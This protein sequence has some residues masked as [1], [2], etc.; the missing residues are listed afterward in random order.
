MQQRRAFWQRRDTKNVQEQDRQKEGKG[1]D[2]SGAGKSWASPGWLTQL[3]QLWGGNSVRFPPRDEQPVFLM[4][5]H[6]IV[7]RRYLWLMPSPKT[8]RTFW[9]APCSRHCTSGCWR[10]GLSTFFPLALCPVSLWYRILRLQNTCF[11]QQTTCSATSTTRAW[12]QRSRNSCLEKALPSLAG[13]TGVC[14]GRPCPLRFTGACARHLTAQ[15]THHRCGCPPSHC[16]TYSTPR[17]GSRDILPRGLLQ[18]CTSW[19]LSCPHTRPIKIPS[20]SCSSA[21]FVVLVCAPGLACCCVLHGCNKSFQ[22]A[23]RPPSP[24][25][26]ATPMPAGLTWK[27]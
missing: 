19:C 14:A 2:A 17:A 7:C 6:D 1:F 18:Q 16:T 5:E 8:F 15:L 11:A 9:V 21:M 4:D 25:A 22:R 24:W 10:A 20:M 23:P 13:I 27:Q 12:L 3:N 26:D